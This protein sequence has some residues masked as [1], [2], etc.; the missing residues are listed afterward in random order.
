MKRRIVGLLVAA[1]IMPGMMNIAAAAEPL[2]SG[3]TAGVFKYNGT[4]P[5]TAAGKA[6]TML[7]ITPR[8]GGS[9]MAIAI[10]NNDPAGTRADPNTAAMNV[11]RDLK[12][13]DLV[14]VRYNKL[15]APGTLDKI[16]KATARPGDADPEAAEFIRLGSVKVADQEYQGVLYRKGG[17]ELTALVPNK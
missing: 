17:R 2:D 5:G 6:V 8:A 3:L 15:P 12:A 7:Q 14:K 9:Q 16:E 4:G 13:G 11:I 10:P 1:L